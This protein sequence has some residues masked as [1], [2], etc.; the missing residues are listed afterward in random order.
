MKLAQ[1]L[2][3]TVE[4][5]NTNPDLLPGVSLGYKIYNGCGNEDL[6]RASI[7]AL[8]GES[9]GQGC[10]KRIQALLGHSSSGISAMINKIIGRFSTPQ[11][12]GL[13]S[14][15]LLHHNNT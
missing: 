14:N 2:I 10:T 15:G 3:F 9:R 11:V 1:T 4:E 8:N 5:I 7:E 12:S 6:I 13:D